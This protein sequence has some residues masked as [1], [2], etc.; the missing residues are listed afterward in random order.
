MSANQFFYLNPYMDGWCQKIVLSDEIFNKLFLNKY[1]FELYKWSQIIN[2]IM[3][4]LS[5]IAI[6]HFN[7]FNLT[8]KIVSERNK[9]ILY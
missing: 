6:D 5:G 1:N 2:T 8:R 7:F 3:S 4:T 9:S